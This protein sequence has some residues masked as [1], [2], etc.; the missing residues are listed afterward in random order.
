MRVDKKSPENPEIALIF[1]PLVETNFGCYYP[2]T[3]VL[4]GYLDSMGIG[5]CQ[6]DLNEEFAVYLMQTERLESMGRGEFGTDWSQPVES[7]AAVSARLLSRFGSQLFDAGG[8]HLFREENSPPAYLLN[9]LVKPLRLDLTVAEMAPELLLAKPQTG[10]LLDFL[11]GIKFAENLPASV[12]TAGIS[13]PVGPQLAPALVLAGYLKQKKQDITI[14]LGGSSISLLSVEDI[15]KLLLGYRSVDAMIASDGEFPL[16]KLLCQ[17]KSGRW[18]PWE[19]AGVS[20]LKDDRLIQIPPAAGPELSR[21]AWSVYDPALIGRLAMP[22]IGITQARGCYWGKCVYCDYIEIYR[23]NPRFRIRSPR[24]FV[25]EMEFQMEKHG[26]DSFSVITEAMPPAFA[27]KIS[28]LI[29]SKNMKLRWHSFAMVDRRFTRELLQLMTA[30]G[31]EFLVIG[32]ETMTDR[33][34]KLMNKMAGRQDNIDFLMRA[35]Q[36]GMNIKINVIPDLPTTTFSES[37]ESLKT[38]E[39]LADCYDFVSCF[40][41]EVTLSSRVGREPERFGLRRTNQAEISGQAQFAVNHLGVEDPAMTRR[42][43]DN[44]KAEYQAFAARI[45][46]RIDPVEAGQASSPRQDACPEEVKFRLAE[47]NLDLVETAKGVQ[48]YNWITR[49]RF[50]IPDEWS[51]LVRK[52]RSRRCFSLREFVKWF[53]P[54]SAGEF[55]FDKMVEKGILEL[56]CPD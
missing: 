24:D 3:A 33:V 27:E 55:I 44:I 25:A 11:E 23:G 32:V 54:D 9:L 43:K 45:N 10:V 41:F 7:I 35:K 6:Y 22:E 13:I 38:C 37:I 34:L 26:V 50:Q 46:S 4:A 30:A 16:E 49:M 15:E 20:C 18:Q 42:E 2:S 21:M 19:I 48:C 36:A 14:I 52:M 31:C 29:I 53:S 51:P 8:R 12:K 1:P 47:Q 17:I 28:R 39:Q 40:P 5:S 56:D